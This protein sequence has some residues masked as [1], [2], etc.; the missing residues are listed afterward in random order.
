MRFP[1][2]TEQTYSV[3]KRPLLTEPVGPVVFS[4]AASVYSSLG[5][6]PRQLLPISSFNL[7][8]PG[9]VHGIGLSLPYQNLLKSL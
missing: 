5:A 6:A 7:Q 8:V 3:S 1:L 2:K 4:P 9:K